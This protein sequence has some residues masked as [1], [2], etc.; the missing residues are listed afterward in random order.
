MVVFVCAFWL[1]FVLLV[2]LFLFLEKKGSKRGKAQGQARSANAVNVLIFEGK[3][4]H[5]EKNHLLNNINRVDYLQH[6]I[7][8]L[9]SR[10]PS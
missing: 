7:A 1:C 2:A 4:A 3:G 5:D 6:V 9:W 8:S 10:S